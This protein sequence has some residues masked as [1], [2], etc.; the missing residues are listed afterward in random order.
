MRRLDYLRNVHIAPI[1]RRRWNAE[2]VRWRQWVCSE[3][4]LGL[5][6]GWCEN[7]RSDPGRMRRLRRLRHLFR[8]RELWWRRCAEPVWR[9]R[10]R[11]H[12]HSAHVRQ[13]LRTRCQRV[14]RLA[15]VR[16]VRCSRDM[17]RRRNTERLRRQ[18]RL[19]PPHVCFGGRD[20]RP[21][22]GWMW[23]NHRVVRPVH[24]AAIVRWRRYAERL[25]W[26]QRVCSSCR[27]PGRRVRSGG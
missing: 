24:P 15:P 26:N 11:R 19:R 14:R 3:E 27:M 16:D 22:R 6:A 25:W 23:G 2:H 9:G 5:F 20:L 7:V 13:Q 4:C 10:R 12:M 17:R 8:H 21:H 18:Q 1:L